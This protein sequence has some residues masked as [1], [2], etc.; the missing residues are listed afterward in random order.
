MLCLNGFGTRWLGLG[1]GHAWC[2]TGAAAGS[3]LRSAGAGGN[4]C[5]ADVAFAACGLVK[6]ATRGLPVQTFAGVPLL[7]TRSRPFA[8]EWL[9]QTQRCACS[10][11]SRPAAA[12][13]LGGPRGGAPI[14][15]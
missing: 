3:S 12:M 15:P 14:R 13:I 4:G 9:L 5:A 6:P 2:C 1:A 7:M 11:L 8:G 10:A